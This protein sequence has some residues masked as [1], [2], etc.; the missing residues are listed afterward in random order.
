M[1]LLLLR[2]STYRSSCAAMSEPLDDPDERLRQ[3][4]ETAAR[5]QAGLLAALACPQCRGE[6]QIVDTTIRSGAVV[7]G[8]IVCP[9][10]G[11][12]GLINGYR[13]SFLQR[14]RDDAGY[15]P[16]LAP[17]W[18]PLSLLALAHAGEWR[19][20]PEGL[21]ALAVGSQIGG[22]IDGSA[23]RIDLMTHAWSGLVEVRFADQ[24]RT[25]DLGSDEPGTESV[26]FTGAGECENAWSLTL[27]DGGTKESAQV[28]L[29]GIFQYVDVDRA[30]PLEFVSENFG[31][32]YPARFEEILR[33]LPEDA[34]VLDLGGGD[35]RHDDP[36]VLNLEYLP[37]RRVD[38]YADGLRLPFA[39]DTFDFILSQAVLEHVPEPQTAVDEIRRVLKPGGL[40][41]A[42]FAFM[43]P[44]HAVPFHFFNIT[45][46][47]AQLLF[48]AFDEVSVSW[49]GGLADTMRWFFRLVDAQ[50]KIPAGTIDEVLGGLD[51]LDGALSQKDLSMLASAVAVEARAPRP[52]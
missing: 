30:Q 46:H 2:R 18:V 14:D 12:V 6:V 36:R 33:S 40:V 26:V 28:V 50:D 19:T 13:P 32:P 29:R 52:A 10:C 11:A 42:D 3:R 38:L 43:Q 37:Y 27:V 21:H 31:N 24:V 41:Y 15:L 25:L 5:R 45:P 34:V 9:R 8:E 22:L 44:L 49:F 17:E 39:D 7:Q 47:G 23:I 16:G 48:Q 20:A 1:P 35:R 51:R 4:I